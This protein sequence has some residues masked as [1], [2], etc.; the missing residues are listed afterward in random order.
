MMVSTCAKTTPFAIKIKVVTPK[1]EDVSDK[2][3]PPNMKNVIRIVDSELAQIMTSVLFK[4]F[5]G[6]FISGIP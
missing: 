2:A 4:Y 6:F 1:R 5:K 3:F